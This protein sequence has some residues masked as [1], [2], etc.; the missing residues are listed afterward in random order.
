M[1]DSR[2]TLRWR[3]AQVV[4]LLA[5]LLL[6]AALVVAPRV[7]LLLLWDVAIPVLPAVFLI[8]PMIWRNICPL[9]TLNMLTNRREGGWVLKNGRIPPA[10]VI[11]M[12]LLALMVP[13]RRVLFNTDGPVLAA[14]IVIVAVLALAL[15]VLFDRKAGFCISI[16]PVLPVERLYGQ[17][18][19]VA[20]GNPRCS[21]CTGCVTRGCLDM[22]QEKSIAQT[23]GRD[24]ESHA[25]LQIPFGVFA[26]SFPGFVLGY[27]LTADGDLVDMWKVYAMVGLCSVGSYIAS[28]LL[29]RSLNLGWKTAMRVFS[30]TG[31]GLYYWFAAATVSEHL[32]LPPWAP[33]LIRA[34]ALIL[35]VT[36]L[37]RPLLAQRVRTE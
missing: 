4:A 33:T 36:W 16:C 27:N 30:A 12:L 3:A 20:M 19:I 32:A 13:A 7:G 15:G 29:V 1:S 17:S 2:S 6:L 14:T 9:G 10:T 34:M 5:T 18:P 23:L 28:Q 26:A 31:F 21:S 25:W 24:R 35:L 8:Q 22:S 11:G 37:S